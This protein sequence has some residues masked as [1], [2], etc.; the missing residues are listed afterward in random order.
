MLNKDT[1]KK[2][3]VFFL[4]VFT[5]LINLSYLFLSINYEKGNYS[6]YNTNL[7]TEFYKNI[8]GGKINFQQLCS[9]LKP[10]LFLQN[11][12]RIVFLSLL[13]I[14]VSTI[15]IFIFY[16]TNIL[17][18]K[19]GYFLIFIIFLPACLFLKAFLIEADYDFVGCSKF[20]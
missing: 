9:S 17:S 8:S 18:K 15:V 5:L 6:E 11:Y 7:K 3:S 10:D 2:I 20:L 1:L 4:V 14:I 13:M 16:K 19:Q 12:N